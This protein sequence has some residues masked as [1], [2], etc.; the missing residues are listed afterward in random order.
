MTNV[1]PPVKLSVL[2]IDD[3][4]DYGTLIPAMLGKHYITEYCSTAKKAIETMATR[5]FDFVL[6]D[7]QMPEI[8]GL[9]LLKQ[10]NEEGLLE[11]GPTFVM[12]SA[13]GSL[14]TAIECL[15]FGAYDY[16]SKPFKRDEIRL[17]FAKAIERERLRNRVHELE[18]AL[19]ETYHF[20]NIVAR[21]KPM[22]EVFEVL[23]KVA[24]YK[25]TVL[26]TGESGTGKELIARA[27]HYSSP[28]RNARF[29][30]VNCGAIPENLLETELFGHV[31]GAFTDAARDKTGLFEEAT[32]GTLFLDEIGE[33]PL[34]LQ[35]KLLR[36]IQ[37]Q[38]VRRVG[39]VKSTPID[40]RIVAAT[41][42]DLAEEVEENKFRE[43]LYYRLNVIP[44]CVPP[45]RDRP[46]DIPPLLEH[47]LQRMNQR[48]GTQIKGFSQ[49]AMRELVAYGWPGN[50]RELE[51]TVERCTLLVESE[52]ITKEVLPGMVS[53][54]HDPARMALLSGDLSIKRTARIVEEA[55]I[56]RALEETGGNRT[57]AAKILEISHRALLYK[58]K[59]YGVDA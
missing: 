58:I 51:N 30:A 29:V 52:V 16:I 8:T 24:G 49:D 25:T 20:G 5:R 33:L 39:A 35:V 14:D 22:H 41:I 45:L 2:I 1:T 9:D 47:F 53:G 26:I 36:V 56:R 32:G 50:V 17:T 4:P 34:G 37:E 46:E 23:R 48:N 59:D 55:L 18:E 43:D 44:I 19:N 27:V 21:S 54:Q 40:V 3:E 42:R 38:E 10:I 11:D 15:S 28:R 31:R 57:H 6:C 12:M 7:V 13:F